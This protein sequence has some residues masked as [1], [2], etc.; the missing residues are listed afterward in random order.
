M[1]TVIE[2][3]SSHGQIFVFTDG[4]ISRFEGDAEHE[5]GSAGIAISKFDLTGEALE[6]GSADI[7]NVGY[8]HAT[9]Y[10]AALTDEE[11]EE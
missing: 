1:K 9:G 11:L 10:E 6:S 7:L 8:W 4:T 5:F 3:G 2:I